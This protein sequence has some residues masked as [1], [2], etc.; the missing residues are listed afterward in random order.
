MINL[1]KI[2]KIKRLIGLM[3]MQHEAFNIDHV[4]ALL[5]I[6]QADMAGTPMITSDVVKELRVP[7]NSGYRYV[8]ELSSDPRRSHL[9]FQAG[10]V[11]EFDDPESRRSKL[12]T[13]TKRGHHFI[14]EL[15]E[16]F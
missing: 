8:W 7:R 11:E 2:Q 6:Y 14:E 4:S 5:A 1:T 3:K 15:L 13:V 16:L 9:R 10:M 12:L